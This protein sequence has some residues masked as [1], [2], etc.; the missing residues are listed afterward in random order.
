VSKN[1]QLSNAGVNAE[2]NALGALLDG[3]FIDVYDG[4]QP[5]TGDTAVSTQTLLVT[6]TFANPA[7]G[8]AVAG[9]ITANA[10]GSGTAG[11]GGTATWFRARK[12]DHSTVVFDG[13]IDTSNANM[14]LPST[15]ITAGQTVSCSALTHTVAK[16]T[17]GF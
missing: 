9:V 3:G 5:A 4:T 14:V 7:F 6:L 17:S 11:S 16:A 10:V 2:A 8:T 1:T 13:S 12:S 15:S